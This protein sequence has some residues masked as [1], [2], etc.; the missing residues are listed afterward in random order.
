MASAI[1]QEEGK[2]W[3]FSEYRITD[4]GA[5]GRRIEPTPGAR[6]S[7]YDPWAHYRGSRSRGGTGA[8]PHESLLSLLNSVTYRPHGEGHIL[9]PESEAAICNWCAAHGL[10]GI[11]TQEFDRIDLPAV[12]MMR[13]T[14]DVARDYLDLAVYLPAHIKNPD[15]W[16]SVQIGGSGLSLPRRVRGALYRELA[17][18]APDASGEVTMVIPVWE[19]AR[20]VDIPKD[21]W[22]QRTGLVS[23]RSSHA[24]PPGTVHEL[25]CLGDWFPSL[26]D[27]A[28]RACKLSHP[29]AAE[30]AIEFFGLVGGMLETYPNYP[31][32]LTP[33][34]WH[35][36][37]ED[38]NEF[39]RR[40]SWL[41]TTVDELAVLEKR[42]DQNIE[43][44]IEIL[45]HLTA[46]ANRVL[47][48]EDGRLQ[49]VWLFPS[50]LASYAMMIAQDISDERNAHTCQACGTR[51][52]SSAYQAKFCSDKCRYRDQKANQ[53]GAAKALRLRK[54][55]LTIDEIA[56]QLGKDSAT[57]QGWIDRAA[58]KET[59]P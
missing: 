54:T 18:K 10:L 25:S 5:G 20:L 48:E 23:S 26:R 46:S 7:S 35:L 55:G 52:L 36:Y 3:R 47:R 14:G 34:F 2:W 50:L 28:A 32:P 42:G 16:L 29:D 40:A 17:K 31:K 39:L 58:K 9:T 59:Q 37:T 33:E 56:A 38:V 1:D 57:V 15:G 4:Y 21:W 24:G 30:D 11:F 49:L 43:L 51:F 8:P 19:L 27:K 53:R 45:N 41:Q 13:R 12:A 44:G 6:L 22:W